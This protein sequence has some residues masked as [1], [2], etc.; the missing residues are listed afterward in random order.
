MGRGNFLGQGASHCKVQVHS[1]VICAKT[2]ESIEMLFGLW[3]HMGRRNHVFDGGP[4]VPRDVA[5]TTNFWLSMG[6]NL[7]CMIASDILFDSR[8][9]F[10]GSS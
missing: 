10:S 6:Y 2:A 3:A 4:H 1:T 9:G 7:G 5:M 8:G